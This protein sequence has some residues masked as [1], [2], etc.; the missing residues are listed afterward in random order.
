MT[1]DAVKHITKES[2]NI[3]EGAAKDGVD[4]TRDVGKDISNAI[5]SIFN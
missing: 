2:V 5:K 4:A 3:T 1:V